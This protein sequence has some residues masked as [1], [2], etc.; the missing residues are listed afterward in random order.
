MF[1]IS[2]GKCL[3]CV[4]NAL[5]LLFICRISSSPISEF[6]ALPQVYFRSSLG[7]FIFTQQEPFYALRL[8]CKMWAFLR[9]FTCVGDRSH[10]SSLL[11]RGSIPL[12][13]H[14]T[15]HCGSHVVHLATCLLV[16]HSRFFKESLA[17][18]FP[19]RKSFFVL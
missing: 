2:F 5:S 11:A 13:G 19:F 6:R 1:V 8:F 17:I 14:S 18:L 7:G 15:A 4:W 3:S 12:E 9:A 16:C 10:L